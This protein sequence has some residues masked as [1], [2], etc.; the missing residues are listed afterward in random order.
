MSLFISE[1]SAIRA[2]LKRGYE[3]FT[4]TIR[5]TKVRNPDRSVDMGYR[6]VRKVARHA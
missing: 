4:Y 6:I 5:L 3:P 2:A 1:K